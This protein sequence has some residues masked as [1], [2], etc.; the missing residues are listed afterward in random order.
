MSVRIGPYRVLGRLGQGGMATVLTVEHE[1]LGKVMALKLLRP[2]E[3][4]EALV[5]LDVLNERFRDEARLMAS[6]EHENIASVWDLGHDRGTPYMVMEYCSVN[7]GLIIGEVR[8]VEEATRPMEPGLAMDFVRQALA[9]L[10]RMHRAGMVHR[11]VKP[12]NLM[13]TGTGRVKLIDL[14]LALVRGREWIPHRAMRVG[15]AYYAAPEQEEDPNGVNPSADL[16]AVGVVL[17]RL[18]SGHLPPEPGRV[19]EQ[20]GWDA[21]WTAFFKRAMNPIPGRRFASAKEMTGALDDLFKRWLKEHEAVC[22][23]DEAEIKPIRVIRPRSDPIRTGVR[24]LPNFIGLDDLLRATNSGSSVF[25]STEHGMLDARTGL[26]W[27]LHGPGYPMNMAEAAEVLAGLPKDGGRA[28]RLPTVDEMATILQTPVFPR[29]SCVP[30]W[31]PH[32]A[33]WVWTSDRRSHRHHWVADVR[34]GAVFPLEP[35]ARITI[36]PVRRIKR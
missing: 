3:L 6:L 27:S 34:N 9:G 2:S 8:R 4:N 25:Q 29:T 19:D 10:D 15:S 7:L 26:E 30:D 11:D 12:H 20:A 24:N 13:L 23:L 1:A 17:Y 32:A 14:G 5:G 33:P 22:R 16:Y 36:L 31:L 35:M 21:K 28:W 18:L